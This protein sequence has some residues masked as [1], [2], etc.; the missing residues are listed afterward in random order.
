[1]SMALKIFGL[2]LGNAGY[3]CDL[4]EN[5]REPYKNECCIRVIPRQFQSGLLFVVD[6][7]FHWYLK[8]IMN[9]FLDF[10]SYFPYWKQTKWLCLNFIRININSKVIKI[11]F[12]QVRVNYHARKE[13]GLQRTKTYGSDPKCFRFNNK[14]KLA[15]SWKHLPGVPNLF[16]MWN[17]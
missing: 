7:F 8:V 10:I 9:F 12:V 1:M 13:L 11:F 3:G 15:F 16:Q 14:N 17:F 6:L 5:L 2:H 4:A